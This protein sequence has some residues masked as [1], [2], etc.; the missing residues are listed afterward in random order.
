VADKRSTLISNVWKLL[1]RPKKRSWSLLQH[2]NPKVLAQPVFDFEL[3]FL[4]VVFCFRPRRVAV[5]ILESERIKA[6]KSNGHSDQE[7]KMLHWDEDLLK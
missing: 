3:E 7:N 6:Q 4:T 1:L 2:L 5:S